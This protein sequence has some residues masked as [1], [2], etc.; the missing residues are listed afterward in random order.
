MNLTN[1][2]NASEILQE[3]LILKNK[4]DTYK[5]KRDKMNSMV[6][7]F[8][9]DVEVLKSSKELTESAKQ[10]YLKVIDVCYLS[11]I[12]EMEDFVNHVLGYVF[13][14]EEYSVRLDITNRYNKS[15]TFYFYDAKKELE[16]LLR[17]GNGKG[18]KAVSSFILMTYY[19]LKMKSPY[20]FLDEAFVNIS[21]GYVERFFEYVKLL[22]H[23]YNMCVVLITHDPRFTEYADIT[24]EVYKGTVKRV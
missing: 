17:K 7:E 21:A 16:T 19:L 20:L 12:K 6:K 9:A 13:V 24:Y 11:S 14:D 3:L 2:C 4:V 5:A 18:V 8:L 22:C 23:K 15:I 10:Y 1:S